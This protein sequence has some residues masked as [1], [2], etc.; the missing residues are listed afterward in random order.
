MRRSLAWIAALLLLGSGAC[1][2][3]GGGNATQSPAAPAAAPAALGT[4]RRQEGKL[5]PAA[6][7]DRPVH[8]AGRSPADT[9][10]S[11]RAVIAP[12]VAKS[13]ATYPDAR[14]RYLSGLPP[15]ETF[16]VTTILVDGDGHWEQ[17]FVLVD[18]I[19]AGVVTGRIFSDVAT[20][21]GWRPRDVYRCSEAEIVDWLISKPDGSEEGNLVGK[22]IDNLPRR[23]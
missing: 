6:P 3:S 17:V 11:W 5:S 8:V 22:F 21:H 7:A 13:M 20:V 14:R 12:Y 9:L 19:E 16:F 10:A 15:G 4:G 18:R 2:T 1:A 23:I